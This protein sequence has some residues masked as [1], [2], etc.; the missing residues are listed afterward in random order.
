MRRLNLALTAA[1]VIG[2]LSWCG[3]GALAAIP[4]SG[5]TASQVVQ[6]P[7]GKSLGAQHPAANSTLALQ[8]GCTYVGTLTITANYVTVTAYGTG[9]PP[10]IT[11]S[12]DGET[13]DV[14][15]SNDTIQGLSLVGKA[16]RTW[17]CRRARTPA[18]HVDG[19]D[20][21]SGALSNTVT[22]VSATGFYAGVFVM[23]GSSGNTIENSTFTNNTMLDTNNGSGSSGA[24]GVLLWGNNNTVQYN[25]I[26]GNQ[27]CSIAYGYDGSAIE[28]YGGSNNLIAD[29]QA[30]NDNAFTEL[31]SYPGATATSNTYQNN[32]VSDGAGGLGMSFLVTRGSLD[33]DGPVHNTIVTN[34]TVNLTLPGDEGAVTYAWQ[35]GDGTLLTLT[36]NYLNL[37]TNEVLYE[38]GGYV[39]GGGNT[40][41]GTCNPTTDC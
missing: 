14:Q 39:N 10:V 37:G 35:A 38:D 32:T 8:S 21:E 33:P 13:I 34:N 28:V 7:C 27:A 24:F 18:G 9:S 16:P 26:T 30:S 17:N 6:V 3:G 25:T 5:G 41:I 36:G 29:N 22:N 31:G 11:Q 23:A 40:F 12:R 1:V 20:I 15:G 2:V 4:A 19:I